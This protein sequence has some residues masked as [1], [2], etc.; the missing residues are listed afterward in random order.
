MKD[1]EPVHWRFCDN[2]SGPPNDMEFSG[3]RSES[4]A[5]TGWAARELA[6]QAGPPRRLREALGSIGQSSALTIRVSDALRYR[7]STRATRRPVGWLALL[8]SVTQRGTAATLPVP[9]GAFHGGPDK[10]R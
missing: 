7:I 8:E 6:Q 3:E 5:T 2:S 1:E 4:A 9:C 10:R